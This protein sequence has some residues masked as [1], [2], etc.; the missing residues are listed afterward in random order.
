MKMNSTSWWIRYVNTGVLQNLVVNLQ[1]MGINTY[2]L[3]VVAG[4]RRYLA[5]KEAGLSQAPALL[6][7]YASAGSA[8]ADG[9]R[10]NLLRKDLYCLDVAEAYLA[11]IEDGWQETQIAR[12]FE[13]EP[14]TI[15]RYLALARYS[16]ELKELIRQ[17]KEI[18]TAR[19]LLREIGGRSY[20]D[21]SE[22]VQAIQA[23]I[24]KI[25]QGLGS[26]KPPAQEWGEVEEQLKSRLSLPAK[27]S[28]SL[29]KGK[30]TIAF[31]SKQEL[32]ALMAKLLP[33]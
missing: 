10:E 33:E 5:A 2:R 4:Q 11:L 32:E 29:E 24:Q 22:L 9:L 7:E 18:F 6:M 20:R 27:F 8:K 23:R 17:H 26:V 13:R 28:G 15:R 30:L 14:R 25:P 1:M 31:G 12:E 21:Q 19:V 3:V 16:A